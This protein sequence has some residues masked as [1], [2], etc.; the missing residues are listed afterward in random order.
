MIARDHY[1]ADARALRA[2]NRV[3]DFRS[4]RIPQQREAEKFYLLIAFAIP[5]PE[6]QHAEPFS[7]VPVGLLFPGP[8][9]FDGKTAALQYHLRRALEIAS[10][11]ATLFNGRA[12]ELVGTV[13][14]QRA[15][16]WTLAPKQAEID[17]TSIRVFEQSQ[18]ERIACAGLLIRVIGQ[19]HRQQSAFDIGAV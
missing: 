7:G 12:H 16:T 2:S 10:Q 11:R 5:T 14:R 15:A 1:H 17:A 9:L 18:L 6:R 13:E 8:A 4:R 19:R 3:R